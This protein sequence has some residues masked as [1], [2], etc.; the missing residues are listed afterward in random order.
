M[1][2]NNTCE[3]P[4][5]ETLPPG[6][7]VV[8]TWDLETTD[9]HIDDYI[10]QIG[11]Y[12]PSYEPFNQ[13]VLPLKCVDPEASSKIH[14]QVIVHEGK[15]VL[16]NTITRKILDTL[17]EYTALVRFYEWLKMVSEGA[18]SN[19]S[20]SLH[21]PEEAVNYS[22]ET[23]IKQMEPRSV[24]LVSHSGIKLDIPVLLQALERHGLT[25]LFFEVVC[26]F[27]DSFAPFAMELRS[28]FSSLSLQS[29]HSALVGI[30]GTKEHDAA[31]DA[32]AVYRVLEAAFGGPL[33]VN[34]PQVGRYCYTRHAMVYY[35]E[36]KRAFNEKAK[37]MRAIVAH[38]KDFRQA[39]KIKSDLLTLG[40]DYPTL[41]WKWSSMGESRFSEELQSKLETSKKK[42][43][44]SY[45]T[46]M[47]ELPPAV[48]VREVAQHFKRRNGSWGQRN[49]RGSMSHGNGRGAGI[50]YSPAYN[51]S[52][53]RRGGFRVNRGGGNDSVMQ[54]FESEG[55]GMQRIGVW[56]GV[57]HE[58]AANRR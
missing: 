26:G 20:E 4:V 28:Q 48:V 6:N 18:T 37:G 36:W 58:V 38:V 50:G 19:P 33:S 53:Q 16:I 34:I 25:E 44:S 49:N 29:L 2:S 45:L 41:C 5:E 40:Y 54:S 13:Y 39:G 43:G 10:C 7:Y 56:R 31:S 17:D 14:L 12:C 52:G 3:P 42:G 32:E 24:V 35:V 8:V 21:A 57:M 27:G 1:M 55:N 46:H 22:K 11:A 47:S 9:R 15:R 51:H 30:E 23:G